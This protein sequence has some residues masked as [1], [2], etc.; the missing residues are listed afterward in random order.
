V[1]VVCTPPLAGGGE[2]DLAIPQLDLLSLVAGLALELHRVAHDLLPQVLV[3]EAKLLGG[4]LEALLL[5]KNSTTGLLRLRK[6]FKKMVQELGGWL[7]EDVVFEGVYDVAAILKDATD[8][9][10]QGTCNI[11]WL[12]EVCAPFLLER[13]NGL[14]ATPVLFP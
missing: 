11:V 7:E 14:L 4:V 3:Q 6:G 10:L 1:R 12:Q 8:K 2:A 5:L 13:I 9:V